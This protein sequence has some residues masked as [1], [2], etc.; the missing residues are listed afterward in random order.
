M[1]EDLILLFFLLITI[2]QR[3]LRMQLHI[4]WWACLMLSI[5]IL[6]T[7]PLCE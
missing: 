4:L 3:L 1:F 5:N 7:Q 2:V 6:C